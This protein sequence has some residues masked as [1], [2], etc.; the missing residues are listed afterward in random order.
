MDNKDTLIRIILAVV[1]IFC[2]VL[3]WSS[4]GNLKKMEL[5]FNEKKATL[6][7]EN[8]DLKDRLESLQDVV[9]K[10]TE[11]AAALEKEKE[12]INGKLV[13]LKEENKKLT[14][15]YG[16]LNV[17]Y[18]AM[19]AEKEAM[20]KQLEELKRETIALATQVTD[21]EK[22]PPIERIKEAMNKEENENVKKVLGEALRN[23]ELIK[24]GKSVDLAPIVVGA[25]ENKAAEQIPAALVNPP[26]PVEEARPKAPSARSG[27]VVSSDTKNNLIIINLGRKD[28][29]KEGQKCAVLADDEEI[30]SGEIISVR[31]D[32]S[33]A[34]ID[35]FKYKNS[36]HDIKEG[37]KVA[38]RE[39][40]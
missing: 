38:V 36:I 4:F 3:V 33:A 27:A 22:S 32:I 25:K 37:D 2:I 18:N 28:K 24:A 20:I 11:A 30:A 1:C 10:K 21:L 14:K 13:L 31:Y 15:A 12:D 16:R 7:K 40:E 8:L 9:N 26:A 39:E 29:I 19:L 35:E 17:N 34:Y 6:V 5:D 23:I